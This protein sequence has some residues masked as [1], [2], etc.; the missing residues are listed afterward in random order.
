MQEKTKLNATNWYVVFKTEGVVT[1]IS[2]PY[3]SQK[4]AHNR[5]NKEGEGW[6]L[7]TSIALARTPMATF[8]WQEINNSTTLIG[9][10]S[11]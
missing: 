9:G 10:K 8:V 4:T 11:L 7:V 5:R 6:V 1:K 2:K 3:A